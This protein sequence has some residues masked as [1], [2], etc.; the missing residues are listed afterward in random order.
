MNKD[1]L[2]NFVSLCIAT[3]AIL[4]VGV[5]YSL[6]FMLERLGFTKFGFLLEAKLTNIYQLM[7]N[8]QFWVVYFKNSL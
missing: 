5:V 1:D 4:P 8:W 2:R 3:A 7:Y 6:V